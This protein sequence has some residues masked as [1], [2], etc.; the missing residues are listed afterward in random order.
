MPSLWIL[1]SLFLKIYVALILLSSSVT[2]FSC[3]LCETYFI[4]PSLGSLT[5]TR[6]SSTN[7]GWFESLFVALN[8]SSTYDF[9]LTTFKMSSNSVFFLGL[10]ISVFILFSE[11]IDFWLW[12]DLHL[13]IIDI[14]FLSRASFFSIFCWVKLFKHKCFMS[15]TC[16]LVK[17]G[18]GFGIK[19]LVFRWL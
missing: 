2:W 14:A 19:F 1:A 6:K 13:F 7:Y 18:Y 16:F 11:S 4:W 15:L 12:T 10:N 9:L 5:W 8:I 17:A 3:S